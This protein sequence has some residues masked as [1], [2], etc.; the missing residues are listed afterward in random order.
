[1]KPPNGDDP[2]KRLQ[3]VLNGAQQARQA[4]SAGPSRIEQLRRELRLLAFSAMATLCGILGL[5]A[6]AW[7]GWMALCVLSF[8]WTIARAGQVQKELK[9]LLGQQ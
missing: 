8:V 4:R 1:M 9:K 6:G 2:I 7:W 3:D 5:T